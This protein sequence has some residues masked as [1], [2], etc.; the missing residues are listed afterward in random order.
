M[1]NQVLANIMAANDEYARNGLR[2]LAVARRDLPDG[3]SD[4]R[5]EVIEQHLSFLG[6][7]AMMDPPREEVALAVEKCHRAGIRALNGS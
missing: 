7:V 1:E 4:Y 3:V 5:S 2:V 6:L